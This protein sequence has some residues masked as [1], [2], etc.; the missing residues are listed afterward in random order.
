MHWY[1]AINGQR[2]GPVQQF[3]FERLVQTGVITPETLVWRQGMDNWLP[4]AQIA[5]TLPA[6]APDTASDTTPPMAGA[7]PE[8]GDD[9]D[10]EVCAVSGLRYPKSQ[11]IQYEGVWV[12]AEHRDTFFQRLREGV[13]A[14]GVM[15]Y[16]GFWIR[17]LAKFID[18]IALWIINAIPSVILSL[19]FLGTPNFLMPDVNIEKGAAL[20][21]FV[22]YNILSV[23]VS[24]GI[25]L[26]YQIF[27]IRK[28]DATPGKLAVGIRLLRADG[29]KLTKG[30][31]IGR[32]FAEIISSIILC[33][34]YI[35]AAFDS[36]KRTLHDQ[37]CDTRVIYKK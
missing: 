10:T 28:F 27:F 9:G 22:I 8:Q 20:V 36:E 29:G 18:G 13:N 21:A 7:A 14:P 33:I 2:T 25:A 4:Y 37:I 35:M 31:I 6:S 15:V 5:P 12:S 32:Y 11:M 26:A 30:R 24:V 3:E 17:L 16:A 34:G 1:Y 23:V 19:I